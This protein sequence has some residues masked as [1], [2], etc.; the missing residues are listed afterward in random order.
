M[1]GLNVTAALAFDVTICSC[2][3]IVYENR[4]SL[5]LVGLIT[6]YAVMAIQIATHWIMYANDLRCNPVENDIFACNKI[7]FAFGLVYVV[8]FARIVTQ[9]K[10]RWAWFG[11][12]TGLV[13]CLSHV[14]YLWGPFLGPAE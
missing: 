10:S 3:W 6:I 7:A 1:R 2:G 11:I 4:A 9:T 8:T 13:M 5:N 12:L 14:V